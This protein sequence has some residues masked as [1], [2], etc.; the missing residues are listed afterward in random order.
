MVVSRPGAHAAYAASG[1]HLNARHIGDYHGG[2]DGGGAV[3][4]W[5]RSP[6]DPGG[7]PWPRLCL[8]CP[9]T[10][11]SSGDRPA[12]SLPPIIHGGRH[13]AVIP[14]GLSHQHCRFHILG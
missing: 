13:R 3:R 5:P 11:I 14:D 8:F 12:F 10:P 6:A 9:D 2:G 7:L 1:K 4:L